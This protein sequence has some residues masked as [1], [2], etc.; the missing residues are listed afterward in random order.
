MS[1]TNPLVTVSKQSEKE[2]HVPKKEK[3]LPEGEQL[4]LLDFL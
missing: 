1:V 4:S 3:K 2:N